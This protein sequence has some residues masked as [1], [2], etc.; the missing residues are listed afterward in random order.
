MQR[1]VA[2]FLDRFVGWAAG[3]DDILAVVLV[4]SQARGAATET[5]DVDLVLVTSH[6]DRYFGDIEWVRTFGT[7]VGQRIEHYGVLDSLRVHYAD[8]LEVEYGV[9]DERWAVDPDPGTRAVLAAGFR[10][11]YE[12]RPHTLTL[13]NPGN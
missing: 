8:P 13:P 7:V 12:R 3:R 1:R 2:E 11:L 10:V 9:T 4:G 6:P 5:S